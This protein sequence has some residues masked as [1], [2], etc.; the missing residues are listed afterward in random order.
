MT[1]CELPQ[2]VTG[3]L[4][5][6]SKLPADFFL[7][8]LT[9]KQLKCLNCRDPLSWKWGG[10]EGPAAPGAAARAHSSSLTHHISPA[11]GETTRALFAFGGL[12]THFSCLCHCLDMNH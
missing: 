9:D 12:L 1:S 10:L 2:S 11:P 6:L 4:F 5:K 8:R 3:S 7:A